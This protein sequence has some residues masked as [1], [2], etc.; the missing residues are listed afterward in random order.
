ML[1][2][3]ENSSVGTWKGR[4]TASW[5][6]LATISAA[7]DPERSSSS[8]ANSSAP[9]RASRSPSPRQV[10]S[11]STTWMRISSPPSCPSR[12]FIDLKSSTSTTSTAIPPPCRRRTRAK[13][14]LR[15]SMKWAR[16]GRRVSASCST[17]TVVSFGSVTSIIEPDSRSALPAGSRVACPR[18]STQ[19]QLPSSCRR[20]C[21]LSNRG[22]APSTCARIPFSTESRSAGWMRSSHSEGVSPPPFMPTIARQESDNQRRS[23]ARSQSQIPSPAPCQASA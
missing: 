11:R 19:R 14:R 13:A 21:S 4:A 12:A 16:F 2:V 17:R 7:P 6:R 15:T 1:T 10:C 8:T 23:P 20:R 9:R 22:A 3:T 18:A 5:M